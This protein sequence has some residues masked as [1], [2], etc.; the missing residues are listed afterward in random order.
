MGAEVDTVSGPE[1]ARFIKR[2]REKWDDVIKSS[3]AQVVE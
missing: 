1:F 3:G 2:E